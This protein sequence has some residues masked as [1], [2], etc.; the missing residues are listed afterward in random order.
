MLQGDAFAGLGGEVEGVGFDAV[1]ALG[2]GAVHGGVG[3]AN[4][5]G[6]VGAVLWIKADAD[7]GAGEEL[8]LAG[9]ERRVEAGQQL[10]GDGAGVTGFVQAGQQDDELVAAQAGHGVDIT[11]LLLQALGNALEQQVADRVAEAVVDVL[12]TVEVKE[13]HRA[14]AVGHLRAGERGLQ[15]VLEQGTIGQAGQRV[16]VG[17]VVELG[18][19]V[20]EAG[21]V[22]EHGDEVG[23][24]ALSVA[25]GADGQPA[26]VQLAVLAFVVDLALP[27]ALIGQLVPHGGIEG[28]VVLAGGKQARGLAE[29]FD[30]AVAG[31]F[32]EGAVDGTDALVD[33]GDQHAFGGVLEHGGGQLQLF[34]HQVALGDVAGDGQHA[35]VA[36][37]R[38]R[39]CR[40]FAEA[41]LPIAAAQVAREVA[42]EA[43][44]VELF[45]QALALVEVDPDAQVQ[46]GLVERRA[47]VIAG[48][49]AEALVHFKQQAVALARQQQAIGRG[50]EGLGEFLFRDLQLLLSFLELADV[51]YRHHQREVAVELEGFGRGQ[52]GEQLAVAAAEAHFQV[53]DAAPVQAFEQPRA[54][55]FDAPQVELGGGAADYLA[56]GEADLLFEGFVHLQQAAVA[57]AGDQQDVGALLEHRGELL[58]GQ[59]QGVLGALGFA[60]VDHQATHHRLVAMLDHADDVAYPQWL[61]I[62]PDY[63]VVEA[64]VAPGGGF[65][66]AVGLGPEGIL[67]V[68]DAAPE[69]GLEPVGQWVAEQAF[70]V[71]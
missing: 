42:Y 59:A 52:A 20:L 58:L 21:D 32:A 51:A 63:P 41:N 43:V 71:G 35:V 48:Q 39:P 24:L 40:E 6:N 55:A 56:R 54:G 31:D 23:D 1:A 22:G 38:Q 11:H 29:G 2:L 36:S 4:Q 67:R 45:D 46:R 66:V 25:H 49:A 34:L 10:V 62:G 26:G 44:A 68:Q 19:G 8:V 70:G 61:A 13:Q 18:L 33:V 28:A 27:V 57:V 14:L 5:C 15:A 17:L 16:V 37:N 53:A 30:L 65:A 3:V 69:A 47:E 60:D 50:M 12:E 64:V 9:L 7:A